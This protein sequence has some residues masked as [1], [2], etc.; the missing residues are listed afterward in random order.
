MGLKCMSAGVGSAWR[1][2]G[3]HM[4]RLHGSDADRLQGSSS[5]LPARTHAGWARNFISDA[6]PY[7]TAASR[8]IPGLRRFFDEENQYAAKRATMSLVRAHM[9][10]A[11]SSLCRLG[12][13]VPSSVLSLHSQVWSA[14]VL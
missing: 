2:L 3:E 10:S 12:G 9:L 4:K 1:E 6:W 8:L 14:L 11:R 5:R 13:S 7:C